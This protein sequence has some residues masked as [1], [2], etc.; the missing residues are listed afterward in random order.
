MFRT[1]RTPRRIGRWLTLSVL[2]LTAAWTTAGRAQDQPTYPGATWERL[3]SPQAL[4]WSPEKLKLAKEYAATINTEAV[5]VVVQGKVLDEWGRTDAKYNIHSIRKSFLSA[6]YGIHVRQNRIDLAKTLEQLGIDDNE[7]SLNAAEK[8]ATVHDL[9][10]ARSGVYHPALY[11]TPAMKAARPARNSH[12]PGTFWYYNNWDFNALGMIFERAVK[13]SIYREFQT[14]IAGPIGMQD[15]IL[16]DGQ[17]FTGADS[18]YAAYPFR[19][20]AR[21]MARFGLLFLRQGSWRGTEV[22]PK[23]W[24]AESTASYSDAGQSGGYGYLWWV[25]VEGRHFPGVV[26]PKGSYSA[27]GAGGHFIL[28][29]PEYDMVIVHRVNTDIRGR[30]VS[31]EQF[32]KL[33]QLIFDA[34]TAR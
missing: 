33:V 19:M 27:R 11:E 9:L 24:V 30:Q 20:T 15:Y 2:L 8:T 16:D 4:G 23:D 3:A 34:R 6:M 1:T 14:R 22:V 7:P 10:K 26:M 21:D 25:A 13:N 28:V 17:Y 18:V 5:M 32:G 31:G 12:A 29:V